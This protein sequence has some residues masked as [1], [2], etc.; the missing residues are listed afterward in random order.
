MINY[1]YQ[2][3]RYY[4]D[5]V[6][7]EFINIG[8][9]F[10]IPEE[11]KLIS[12]IIDNSSRLSALFHGIDTKFV[13]RL[14]R[15]VDNW[16]NTKGKELLDQLNHKEYSSIDSITRSILP[17]NDSSL[18]FSDV[19]TGIT[20]D[21]DQTFEEM[22]LRFVSKFEKKSESH[23]HDD[24]KAWYEYKKVFEKYSI[25]KK[26][27]KPDFI[28][29]TKYSE[30]EFDHAWKNGKWNFYKPISFDLATT[31]HIR[32]KAWEQVGFT[33]EL[34]TSDLSFNLVYLALSPKVDDINNLNEMLNSKFTQS[35]EGKSISIVFED[36]AEEFASQ[37]SIELKEHS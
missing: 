33:Q 10:F 8:I 25:D 2:I 7:E 23:S 5:V 28:V 12:K 17:P 20:L 16:L 18:R 29:K 31:D 36:K 4:P 22:Y 11:R 26:L 24:K 19:R 37:L 3:L 35:I 21:I 1:Q 32:K 27:T 9:V 15:N 30:F 6:A 34:L 14:L 13:N